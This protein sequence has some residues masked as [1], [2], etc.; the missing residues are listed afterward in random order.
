MTFNP[1]K[2]PM[3]LVTPWRLTTSTWHEHIPFAF[4]CMEILRPEVLVELGTHRG[5]SY[6]AFCQAVEALGLP[7][8]TYAVDTWRG[9]EHSG[10]YEESVLAELRKYHDPLYGR[11]SRLVRSTFDEALSH[12]PDGSID[13][14]HIDGLHTYEAIKHDF[15]SWQPKMSDKG[16]VLFHDTNVRE[17]GFGVWKLWQELEARYPSFEF[18]HGHGLGVLAV[19][20]TVNPEFSEIISLDGS[21]KHSLGMYYCT[22]GQRVALAAKSAEVEE[23]RDGGKCLKLCRLCRFSSFR[24]KTTLRLLRRRLGLVLPVRFRRQTIPVLKAQE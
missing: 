18:T 12:F 15:E 3:S 23:M 10:L 6:L 4:T 2:F 9:D 19:G 11:F 17:R 8:R 21:Q 7:T 1:L 13:L 16:V 5:D 14:L 20:N 22:L 24:V